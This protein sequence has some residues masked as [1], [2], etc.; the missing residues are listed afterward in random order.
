MDLVLNDRPVIDVV[1]LSP[2]IYM[3]DKVFLVL[4]SMIQFCTS[5]ELLIIVKFRGFM[6]KLICLENSLS[7]QLPKSK[8]APSKFIWIL[9]WKIIYFAIQFKSIQKVFNCFRLWIMLIMNNWCSLKIN[10]STWFKWIMIT[11][12]FK[13]LTFLSNLFSN[14]SVL[15]CW[16][17]IYDSQ[18]LW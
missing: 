2:Y 1:W 5:P 6:K 3:L 9:V 13:A 4:T 16:N 15:L 10:S 11:V 8:W 7:F 18:E 12:V 17:V 14:V